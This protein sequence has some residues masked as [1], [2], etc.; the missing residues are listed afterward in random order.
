MITLT[1]VY[2]AADFPTRNTDQDEEIAALP[3]AGLAHESP[4]I[5]VRD[6]MRYL[7]VLVLP[8]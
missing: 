1:Q 4:A 6:I 3:D 5:F 8:P 7:A 2:Y